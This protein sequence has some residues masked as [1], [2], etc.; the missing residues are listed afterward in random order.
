MHARIDHW[1]AE[2]ARLL[3]GKKIV[4]ASYA[5][6]HECDALGWD[7]AGVV[8][9]FEDTTTVIVSRDDE[10]N[11]PGALFVSTPDGQAQT[12]PVL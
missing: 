4:R 1:N 12:L 5:T 7:S 11:G 2:A 6:Q 10:G 8:F 9:Q 3:V